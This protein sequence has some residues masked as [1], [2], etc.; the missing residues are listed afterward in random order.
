MIGQCLGRCA[1]IGLIAGK[2]IDLRGVGRKQGD[3]CGHHRV[4]AVWIVEE[5][6]EDA[7]R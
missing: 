5:G 6:D 1:R 3:C 2:Q 7:G 4:A